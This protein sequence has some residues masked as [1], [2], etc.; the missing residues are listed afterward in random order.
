MKENVQVTL[1]VDQVETL[2]IHFGREDEFDSIQ[3]YE[4]GELVD[5]L[6][7]EIC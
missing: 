3:D 2:L 5:Q 4:V 1:T 6:I 7:D